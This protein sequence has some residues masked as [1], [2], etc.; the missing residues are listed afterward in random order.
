MVFNRR[1]EVLP[2]QLYRKMDSTRYVFE[3]M[4]VRDD[5]GGAIHVQMRRRDELNSR[6]TLAASVLLD[7]NEFELLQDVPGSSSSA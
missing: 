3:V 5:S 4:S 2:G 1:L 6:R 7:P